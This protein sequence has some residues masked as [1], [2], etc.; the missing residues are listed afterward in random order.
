MLILS[1]T[2]RI[3]KPQILETLKIAF[4]NKPPIE[5]QTTRF[6][7]PKHDSPQDLHRSSL[8]FK[9]PQKNFETLILWKFFF[10]LKTID[11]CIKA[12]LALIPCEK[13]YKDQQKQLDLWIQ[14]TS[15]L[16]LFTTS[17]NHFKCDY[18]FWVQRLHRKN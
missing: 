11:L 16:I 5:P 7:H 14:P 18:W 1:R 8:N 13:V 3:R 17:D 15:P 2:P 9:N 12:N 4:S 10:L 6:N